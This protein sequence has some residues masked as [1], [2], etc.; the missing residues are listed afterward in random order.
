MKTLI[1]VASLGLFLFSLGCG[2]SSSFSVPVVPPVVKSLSCS[3]K[4]ID[5]GEKSTTYARGNASD[6]KVIPGTS[7]PAVAFSDL[8]ALVLK[9]NYWNGSKEITEVIGGDYS[10]TTIRLLFTSAG[11]P[12]VFWTS[13]GTS[14]KGAVRSAPV[15]REGTWKVWSID[16]MASTTPPVL[17]AAINPLDQIGIAYLTDSTATGRAKFL[18]CSRCVDGYSFSTMTPTTY[19][20]DTNVVVNT[21]QLGMAWCKASDTLYYP[22]VSY[23]TTANVQYAVCRQSS[24]SS[25]LTTANWNTQSVVA[26]GDVGSKLYLDPTVTGDVPKVAATDATGV[27]TYQMG[28]TA[29]TAAP[30]AFS[31]GATLGGAST[32]TKAVNIVKDAAG[33]F[34]LMA[35][36]S[37]TSLRYY[38]STGTSFIG[39]WNSHASL[40]TTA[41]PTP[42]W[43]GFAIDLNTS[44]IYAS[45][46]VSPGASDLRIARISNYSVASDSASLNVSKYQVDSSGNLQLSVTP[47]RHI[48]AKSTSEG[49]PATAYIDYSGSESTLKY[50]IRTGT[51]ASDEWHRCD[52]PDAITPQTPSLT[53]DSNDHPWIAYYDV[54]FTR[55]FLATTYSSDC[56][57]FWTTYEF[58]VT[59]NGV[60]YVAGFP[61]SNDVAVTMYRSNGTEY[62]LVA[63]LDTN[64]VSKGIYT[65]MLNPATG[66][67]TSPTTAVVLGASTAASIDADSDSSGNAVVVYHDLT[68]SK[69]MYMATRDGSTWSTPLAISN[70]GQG[71]GARIRIRPSSGYP[72]ISFYDRSN[73]TVYYSTCSATPYSCIESGWSAS[74]IDLT[75][76][77]STFP[78]SRYDLLLSASIVYTNDDYPYV[79]YPRGKTSDGNLIAAS[80]GSTVTNTIIANGV[81]GNSADNAAFNFAVAGW[82]VASA[83]NAAGYFTSVFL[84]P[85][86]WIYAT[87]CGD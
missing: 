62:P 80:I 34:H 75:A 55:F 3:S 87:S 15:T 7:Y 28:S 52:V 54:T 8:G 70:Y 45:F 1:K 35:N 63:I 5:Y 17:E 6:L 39:T 2:K 12:W 18:F 77:V 86:D 51:S 76:G 81:N 65:S 46:G 73:N 72:S 50:A 82:G 22:A 47:K 74:A 84:G 49:I 60:Q 31:A 67:W 48:S 40:T 68:L 43:H 58:P 41:L 4:V 85:G 21:T 69:A 56:G 14:V 71:M 24:L 53:F 57:G 78:T 19:V 61:G 29:C 36:E 83:P 10:V 79:V 23:S 27:I 37:T 33:R 38:N 64:A 16:T 42:I 30:T 26:S 66:Q 13:G 11:I 44:G 20:E 32:G 9:F 59:P 25:C